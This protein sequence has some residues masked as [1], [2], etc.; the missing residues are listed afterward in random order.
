MNTITKKRQNIRKTRAM[1]V[2]QQ[3]KGTATKP[4]LSV[5]KTNQHIH[6]QLIDDEAGIT[7]GYVTT[8]SKENRST[9]FSRKN[10]TSARKLGENIAA[11]AK[12]KSIK[13]VIF[14]RGRF[15]YHGIL[16]ELANAAR[17]AGLQ[18]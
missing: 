9:E 2:R 12:E 5:H 18:F 8:N 4:R 3:M 1:R 14:D 13:E 6:A 15:K 16:A 11:I 10:K 17:E 7:L